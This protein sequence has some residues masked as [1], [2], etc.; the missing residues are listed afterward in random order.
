MPLIGQ[1]TKKGGGVGNRLVPIPMSYADSLRI[2]GAYTFGFAGGSTYTHGIYVSQ[3]IH[4][5]LDPVAA[6]LVASGGRQYGE[7][8]MVENAA[9]VFTPPA[10]GKFFD[11]FEGPAPGVDIFDEV[12]GVPVLHLN[13]THFPTEDAVYI[14]GVAENDG[15]PTSG[16]LTLGDLV[17]FMLIYLRRQEID[18]FSA[19]SAGLD[20]TTLATALALAGHNLKV[21]TPTWIGGLVATYKLATFTKAAVLSVANPVADLA[22]NTGLVD[23]HT[24]TFTPDS[25]QNHG[26]DVTEPD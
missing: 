12:G 14:V 3:P 20:T 2:T 17:D 24:S 26:L 10:G 4:P 15:G 13:D 21:R 18:I 5:S 6:S 7:F 11:S 25:Q 8:G 22:D 16:S 19:A 9:G 1:P 23:T